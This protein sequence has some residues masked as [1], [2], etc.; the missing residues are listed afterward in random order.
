MKGKL[1]LPALNDHTALIYIHKF[2][3]I[4]KFPAEYKIP[5][6]LKIMNRDDRIN[7]NLTFQLRFNI[8]HKR[9]HTYEYPYFTREQGKLQQKDQ[10]VFVQNK[11]FNMIKH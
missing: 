2:P 3:E 6:I 7:H 1:L 5:H 11:R 4:M 10:P 8:S 9:K